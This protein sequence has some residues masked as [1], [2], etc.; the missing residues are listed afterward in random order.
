MKQYKVL[1]YSYATLSSEDLNKAA[2]EGFVV[3]L[4]T[5]SEDGNNIHYTVL[6]EKEVE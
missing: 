5:Q 2:K 6:L 1:T 3:K 4:L